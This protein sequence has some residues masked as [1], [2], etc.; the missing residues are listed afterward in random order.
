MKGRALCAAALVV[1]VFLNTSI[2]FIMAAALLV[3]L[4]LPPSEAPPPD[5]RTHLEKAHDHLRWA[6]GAHSVFHATMHYEAAQAHFA[7]ADKEDS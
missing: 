3:A 5:T 2:G 7:A 4:A 1:A 6:D